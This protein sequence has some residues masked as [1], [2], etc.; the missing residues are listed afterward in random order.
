MSSPGPG[1]SLMTDKIRSVAVNKAI[2]A[3]VHMAAFNLDVDI[4][5]LTVTV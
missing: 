4:R 3:L 1:T 5:I 2:L